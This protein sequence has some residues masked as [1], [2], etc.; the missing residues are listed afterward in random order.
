[1]AV[2][3]CQDWTCDECAEGGAAL[4]AYL[5]SEE[6]IMGEILL[7]MSEICPQHPDPE[8]CAQNIGAFWALLGPIVWTEHWSHVCDDL[9]CPSFEK[10]IKV[11]Y[12][13]IQ[14]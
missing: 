4:G 12:L 8:Y 7:L 1:M 11:I 10:Q 13:D 2:A 9:E 6:N 14:N 3:M 5:S